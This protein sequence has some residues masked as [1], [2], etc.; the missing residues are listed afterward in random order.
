MMSTE[1]GKPLAEARG[2][3]NGAADQFEWYAEEAKRV[4][5]QSI[6]GRARRPAHERD[7]PAG[8]R[9][10]ALSAWNFPALLPVAQDRRGDGGGLFRHRRGPPPRRRA[11]ASCIGQ[12][13]RCRASPPGVVT[14]LTGP[15]QAT[16]Q[17]LIASPII[18][19]VSLTG[20]VAGRQGAGA[21]VRRGHEAHLD[22]TRRP[23]PGDRSSRRRS[24]RR[25]ARAA[26]AKFRNCGQV[27][28][29]PIALLRA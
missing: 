9:R 17:Q 13:Y 3:T 1:T 12:A 2:E 6:P 25:R 10:L 7:L 22:G 8:R 20:S 26:T 4:Y 15:A 29:S 5:G 18:R 27:C 11:H 23:C 24:R 28:I 19:K 14:I 21:P 16:V